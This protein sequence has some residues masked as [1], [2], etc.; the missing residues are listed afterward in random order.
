MENTDKHGFNFKQRKKCAIN[1][2]YQIE[3][4]LHNLNKSIKA[5]KI[6]KFIK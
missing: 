4:F 6:Y 5:F 1:S 3:Y 2:I